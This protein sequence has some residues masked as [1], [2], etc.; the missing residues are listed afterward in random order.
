MEWDLVVIGA[1]QTGAPL[2]AR[3]AEA[4]KRVLLAER[5]Y[6]GGTCANYGCTPTK[7]LIASARAAHVARTAGR[8]GI[9]TDVRVDFAAVI[10]RKNA[11]VQQW[12][13][14]SEKRL[15]RAGDA[16]TLRRAHA[17]FVA[18]HTIEIEGERHTAATI[19]IDVG[20]R[21]AI[22]RIQGLDEVAWL[23]NAS[24]MELTELPEHL[25]VLGGG[26]IGC[27]LGQA[28]RRFGSEITILDASRHLLA[29][30]DEDI[31]Q[32]IEDVFIREGIALRLGVTVQRIGK[33]AGGLEIQT[34]D[35]TI[36]GTHLLVAAGRRPNTDDLGCDA[37]G[38]ELADH[39]YI[40][41]DDGYQTNVAGIYAA[42]D[43][44]GGPQFT[45]TAWDDHRLLYD[46]VLGRGGR[47]RR[48][49]LVPHATFTDPQ[50]AGIGIT[51]RKAREQ[52]VAFE[53]AT[54]PFG[55]IA[56]AIETDEPAG[57]IKVMLDPATQ[58]ILGA[59]IAGAEAAELI[60]IFVA[61]IAAEASA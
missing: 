52:G 60:H 39:G 44:T 13:Q 20:T 31:S 10:R 45:H 4:G 59:T 1:G 26:Y 36:T 9:H 56:R 30:E 47:T 57:L 51:E 23:D 24:V 28:F 16:L 6:V 8:L 32:V 34:S 14:S 5:K 54:F 43:V 12:R 38:I 42:G 19:I 61:T 35:G 49:R 2:A 37:A 53:L 55:N 25:L 46:L 11:L 15:A 27:E 29:R 41:V 17:R 58:R 3:L 48:D 7:T 21:P 40:R 33:R 18:D 22:P 50:I